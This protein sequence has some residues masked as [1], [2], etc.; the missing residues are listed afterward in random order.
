MCQFM[1]GAPGTLATIYT[2][3]DL[4]F[5]ADV[6][7]RAEGDAPN[8]WVGA[9]DFLSPGA[10]M[11]TPAAGGLAVP[12]LLEGR[13]VKPPASRASLPRQTRRTGPSPTWT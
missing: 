12:A 6:A 11:R 10:P 9:G 2:L 5:F 1:P 13:R 3:E 7:A 8:V 4:N